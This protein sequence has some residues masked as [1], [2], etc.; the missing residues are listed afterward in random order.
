MNFQLQNEESIMA[1]LEEIDNQL[2]NMV[3]TPHVMSNFDEFIAALDSEEL[4]EYHK[5][6]IR[7]DHDWVG[8]GF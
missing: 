4:A 3:F 2:N 8:E 5:E 7:C 6:E 1:I